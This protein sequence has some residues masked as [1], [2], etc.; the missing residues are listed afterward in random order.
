[1]HACETTLKYLEVK[2]FEISNYMETD[3]VGVDCVNLLQ[4]VSTSFLLTPTYEYIS[5]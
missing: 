3:D 2:T 1:M 4:Y 5:R